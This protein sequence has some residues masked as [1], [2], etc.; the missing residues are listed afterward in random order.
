MLG[1][2]S[3]KGTVRAS[4]VLIAPQAGQERNLRLQNPHSAPSRVV[5]ATARG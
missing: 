1:R 3:G 5:A 4:D 2:A